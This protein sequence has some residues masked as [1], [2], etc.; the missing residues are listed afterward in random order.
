[1]RPTLV[2]GLD[3]Y[4]RTVWEFVNDALEAAQSTICAGGRYDYLI[5]DIGGSPTPGVGWAAGVERMAMSMSDAAGDAS[6]SGIE[7][8]FAFED[9]R[10][11]LEL[12]PV[13]AKLR[14]EGRLCDTDYAGR[15]LKGQLTQAQRLGARTVVIARSDGLTLRRRRER[16][17]DVAGV[18]EALELL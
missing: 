13:M 15:S 16:D 17:V 14:A 6:T 11:R 8:F 4:T 1:V 12:L 10:R 3:Y 7:V 2:R 9:P 5:E 18:Q